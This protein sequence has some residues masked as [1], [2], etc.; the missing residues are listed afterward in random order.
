MIAALAA[1]GETIIEDTSFIERGYEAFE[2]KLRE[3]G[4]KIERISSDRDLTK[5]H[6][7]FA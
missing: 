7:R 2:V 6:L 5:F 4:A 1:E 3:L